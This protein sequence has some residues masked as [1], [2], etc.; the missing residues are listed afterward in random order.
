LDE[1]GTN[2]TPPTNAP[3]QR[4]DPDFVASPVTNA[5]GFQSP[6]FFA[7]MQSFIQANPPPADQQRLVASFQPV[8]EQ[9]EALTQ[10]IVNLAQ[11]VM[12]LAIEAAMTT[13][14]GWSFSLDLGH[15]KKNY[16]LRAAVARYGLDANVKEDAVY[17]SCAVSEMGTP[18]DGSSNDTIHF[19]AGQQPP[20]NGFWSITV[21]DQNGFLVANSI[22]RYSVGSETGLVPDGDGGL[23][24][25]LRNSEPPPG[26]QANWL[27]CPRV[28]PR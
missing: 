12:G 1:Y 10:G 22:N 18:L 24:I 11:A 25:Q 13:V 26:P 8:F 6:K 5:P 21:Y 17:A 27:P 19:P 16:L 14:N 15:H 7:V 2:Y 4:P 20:V 3:F 28:R 9:P 23:T